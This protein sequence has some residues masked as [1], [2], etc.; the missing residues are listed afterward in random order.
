MG[1]V[2]TIFSACL[3]GL[4]TV[5]KGVATSLLGNHGLLRKKVRLDIRFGII[6]VRNPLGISS[7]LRSAVSTVGASYCGDPRLPLVIEMVGGTNVARRIANSLP[8]QKKRLVTANKTMVACYSFEAK[9]QSRPLVE[10]SV[11]GGIPIVNVIRRDLVI[12]QLPLIRGIING[13]TNWLLSEATKSHMPLSR[14]TLEAARRGYAEQDSSCDIDGTDSAQK[15]AILSSLAAGS[16]TKLRCVRTSGIRYLRQGDILFSKE[17]GFGPKL[18]S[19]FSQVGSVTCCHIQ[20]V[21][22]FSHQPFALVSGTANSVL[23]VGS[24]VGNVWLF[25]KGAGALPSSSSVFSDLGSVAAIPLSPLPTNSRPAYQYYNETANVHYLRSGSTSLRGILRMA[26]GVLTAGDVVTLC[27][28]FH[29]SFV[30]VTTGSARS[31]VRTSLVDP[32]WS[33]CWGGLV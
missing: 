22:V 32:G 10:A 24:N 27:P 13:T 19:S 23:L 33:V 30:L 15:V 17:L 8:T 16:V 18:V 20:P 2:P 6:L 12:N 3:L 11:G 5:G 7:R 14:L 21:L 28:S 4:G 1:Q 31:G 26:K 9:N 25:G 29:S